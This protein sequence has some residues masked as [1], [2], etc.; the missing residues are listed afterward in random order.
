MK[1][2]KIILKNCVT[3]W[4]VRVKL[5]EVHNKITETAGSEEEL[6]TRQ[7]MKKMLDKSTHHLFI[8]LK[9]TEKPMWFVSEMPLE[10]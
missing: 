6:Y 1:D 7:W 4:N 3:D 2:K 5:A 9:C 8:L 10:F